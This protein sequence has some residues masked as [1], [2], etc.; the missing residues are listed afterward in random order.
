MNLR[1]HTERPSAVRAE[2]VI[3]SE[4][5]R[6]RPQLTSEH[7]IW[8]LV[9]LVLAFTIR[10]IDL[11]FNSAFEGESFMILM[12]RSVLARASDVD[13]YLRT[14]F[15]WYPWPAAVAIVDRFGGLQAARLLTCATG[16]ATALGV[17]FLARRLFDERTGLAAALLCALF[18][19]AVLVSRIATPDAAGMALVAFT[20]AMVARAWHTESTAAWITAAALAVLAVL[21]KHALVLLLPILCV[22][23]LLLEHR[24]GWVFTAIVTAAVVMYIAWYGPVLRELLTLMA[25]G[26]PVRSGAG[27]LFGGVFSDALD[28]WMLWLLAAGGVLLGDRTS[29]PAIGVLCVGSL[30]LSLVPNSSTFDP[31]A[32]ANDV[33][34]IVPLLPAAAVGAIAVCD[35]I[36]RQQRSLS[37]L[38][39]VLVAGCLLLVGGGDLVPHRR[40]LLQSWPNSTVVREFVHERVQYGQRVLVDDAALRYILSDVTP[41]SRVTDERQLPAN[42]AQRDAAK[43]KAVADGEFDYVVLDGNNSIAARALDAS[44]EPVI[45]GRYVERLRALQPNTGE[46]AVIYERIAPP[47]SR[48]IDA[49]TVRVEAP[50]PNAVIATTGQPPGTD[51]V[52]RVEHAP[53]SA[54]LRFDV[55]TDQWYEQGAPQPTSGAAGSYRRRVILGGAGAQRCTHIVRVRLLSL[56]DRILHEVLVGPITRAASDSTS[57]PCVSDP[58]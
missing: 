1:H 7:G 50:L 35:R 53:R 34:A 32:W 31:H 21:V 18:A 17:F 15:G 33:H 3:A 24:R 43:A 58:A 4:R 13:Q 26:T 56:D 52:V 37:G 51:V 5:L 19:P 36:V 47:V 6:H 57:S 49:P 40:G 42:G 10:A 9:I 23:T 27:S 38:L 45:M 54:R 14:A 11:A 48:A 20:L 16:T 44:I 12:G 39:V 25:N 28:V 30:A 41:Q 55:Y 29:R 8:L 2:V 22:V 46:D